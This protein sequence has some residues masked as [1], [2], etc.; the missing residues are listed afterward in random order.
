MSN[1]NKKTQEFVKEQKVEEPS[2]IKLYLLGN[3]DESLAPVKASKT[4]EWWD[5][6]EIDK[7]TNNHA[8][9]CLP[10]TMGAGAGYYILS[11][12]TFDVGWTGRID[13]DAVVF[14]HDDAASHASI[15]T[16]STH[17]GFTVQAAFVPRTKNPGDFIYVKGVPNQYRK[18][19]YA[20]EAMIEAWWNPANFGIVFM[21][22]QPGQFRIHKGEPIA[23]MMLVKS[24][25][26]HADLSIT[27]ETLKEHEDFTV[28][29]SRPEF[30]GKE[31]DYMKGLLPDGT[32]VCPHFKHW[33]NKVDDETD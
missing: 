15:S 33:Y 6:P 22:N 24:S 21:L 14:V 7:K 23:Q 32:E 25:G 12:A 31:F 9:F 3:Y 17:G 18:P 10:M 28:K 4:R 13:E 11:P 2:S 26:L 19:Y 27:Q 8:K 1:Q 30:P 29:R 16:H 20:L 5:D